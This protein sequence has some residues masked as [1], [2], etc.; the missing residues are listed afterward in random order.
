MSNRFV[1]C[2]IFMRFHGGRVE[3]K[4]TNSFTAAFCQDVQENTRPANGD[5]QVQFAGNEDNKEARLM[6]EED[7]SYYIGNNGNEDEKDLEETVN[8]MGAEDAEGY[9]EL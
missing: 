6:E 7:Y 1:D 8:S 5:I 3:H 2:D 9:S 4:A